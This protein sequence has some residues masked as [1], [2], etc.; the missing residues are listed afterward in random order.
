MMLFQEAKHEV[1]QMGNTHKAEN[2]SKTTELQ[3][4][5]WMTEQILD[6]QNQDP[7]FHNIKVQIVKPEEAA[8]SLFYQ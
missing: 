5:I 1:L 7:I 4:K 6:T 3:I 2:P 8:I